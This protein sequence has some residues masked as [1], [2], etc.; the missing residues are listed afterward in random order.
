MAN[1]TVFKRYPGNPIITPSA[2]PRANSIHNSAIVKEAGGYKG[3]FRVDE[4]SMEYTLHYGESSDGI[5]WAIQPERIQMAGGPP[6]IVM[7]N[8]SYDP[9]I[10]RLEDAYYITWCNSDEHGPCIG[11]AVTRD[12]KTFEQGENPLPPANRNAVLFP[13]RINGK[14]AMLHRPSD[15]SH[16]AFGDVFYAASPDLIHWGEHR[17]VLGPTSGWQ[18]IKTGPG[19]HPIETPEGW[20]LF[21]HGVWMSCNGFIYSMGAALLDL[22]EPWRVIHRTKDYL[23]YPTELYERVGDVPNVIFPSAATL[24]NDGRTVRVYYGCAD[25]CISMAEAELADVLEFV[26]THG[27]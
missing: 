26:K 24:E 20:L 17:F 22:D 5:S 2:V 4:I 15:R 16:T 8:Y 11:L 25:T 13:R 7:T 10:T 14:Y 6:G 21:Y 23:L 9:R 27:Y 19:P 18:S 1:E 3:L 12:F